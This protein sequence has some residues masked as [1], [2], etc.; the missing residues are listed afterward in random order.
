MGSRIPCRVGRVP[1]LAFLSPKG[2]GVLP[3]TPSPGL[4]RRSLGE[5]LG[6]CFWR[7][8][9]EGEEGGST[10]A[11]E[12]CL[13]GPVPVPPPPHPHPFLEEGALTKAMRYAREVS[14]PPPGLGS[15]YT[16]V[17]VGGRMAA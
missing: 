1:T 7:R 17:G 15:C 9:G 12:P 3:P 13:P 4:G 8:W 16:D 14:A 5:G 10:G 11:P 2:L 6:S